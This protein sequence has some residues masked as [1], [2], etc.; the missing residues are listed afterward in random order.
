MRRRA[1][2][3]LAFPIPGLALLTLAGGCAT[4]PGVARLDHSSLGCMRSVVA[5]KIPPHISDKHAHCLAA[6]FI[7]RY[8]SRSE[9]YAAS[10]GKE[11]S[12]LFNGSN[13]FEWAD[14]KADR[15]GIRCERASGSDRALEACCVAA[16]R[17]HHL[18]ISPASREGQAAR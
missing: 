9:A 11:F 6:G 1:L 5:T 7:A 14:L 13:D 16:L 10:W 17:V 8:C 2:E 18:P 4:A 3:A 12:D 15:L